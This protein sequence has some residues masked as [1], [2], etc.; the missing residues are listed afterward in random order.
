MKHKKK[1]FIQVPDDIL[2]ALGVYVP[3]LME[4]YL[5]ETDILNGNRIVTLKKEHTYQKLYP[6]INMYDLL[7]LRYPTVPDCSYTQC[8]A[9]LKTLRNFIM[10]NLNCFLKEDSL[11]TKGILFL[12]QLVAPY[13]KQLYF[14]FPESTDSSAS[15]VASNVFK[16]QKIIQIN[17]NLPDYKDPFIFFGTIGSNRKRKQGRYY[18][19]KNPEEFAIIIDIGNF[20]AYVAIHACLHILQKE[21]ISPLITEIFRTAD[22]GC[23][24]VSEEE[25][26]PLSLLFTEC[27]DTTGFIYLFFTAKPIELSI[28]HIFYQ[29]HELYED[30]SCEHEHRER[31]H[32]K[33][34]TAYI[35]KKNI[36]SY[37]EDAMSKSAFLKYFGYVE[38]DEEVDLDSISKIEE[39]FIR[40]SKT[41]FSDASWP[42]VSLRFRKLGK[43]KAS[44]LYFPSLHTLCVDIRSPA[45]FIHE[46]F[47]ML[48]DQLGDISLSVSF[49]SIVTEYKNA[50]LKALPGMNPTSV[51]KLRGNTKYN[52]S[53]FFRRA[54]IFARCGEIYFNRI[55]N[56]KTSLLEPDLT[57]AYPQS[58][59]LDILIKNYYQRLLEETLH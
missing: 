12:S 43:H 51:K 3:L 33:I 6:K 5:S 41:Y 38:Y 25:P 44:G 59:L 24:F 14:S 58:D 13:T 31:L 32:Q 50:F 4:E 36:P 53:Y 39:E 45:S 8:D 29:L 21:N 35:T 22:Y 19:K 48:D 56:V 54:E 27:V 40:L 1:T 16:Q 55:L 23:E 18:L 34:A 57:Y 30:I 10:N 7:K 47:H 2:S 17:M 20:L 26:I 49:S 28:V 46:Y 42:D 52:M 37:I 9:I 15:F 11:N